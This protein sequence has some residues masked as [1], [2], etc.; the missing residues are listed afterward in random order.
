MSGLFGSYLQ[1]ER[2]NNGTVQQILKQVLME[3]CHKYVLTIQLIQLQ[4]LL[5]N[6]LLPGRVLDQNCVKTGLHL[7]NSANFLNFKPKNAKNRG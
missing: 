1:N 5:I 2:F 6:K 3:R 7:E 4:E